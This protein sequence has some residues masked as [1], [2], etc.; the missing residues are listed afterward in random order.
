MSNAVGVTEVVE[1]LEIWARGW[2]DEPS[3]VTD[4]ITALIADW[5]KRGDAL[6]ELLACVQLGDDDYPGC[7]YERWMGARLS[8]AQALIGDSK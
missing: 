6:R 8:A 1:R 5:R 7:D 4:Y 2:S 3:W